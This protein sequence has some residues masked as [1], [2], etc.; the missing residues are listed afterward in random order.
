M[1]ARDGSCDGGLHATSVGKEP[2]RTEGVQLGLVVHVDHGQHNRQYLLDAVDAETGDHAGRDDSAHDPE[3]T[4]QGQAW[5]GGDLDDFD[6]L[7]AAFHQGLARGFDVECV[8][9]PFNTE[10]ELVAGNVLDGLAVKDG[11]A[12]EGQLV[13]D[14]Q[15]GQARRERCE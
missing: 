7:C 1:P 13:E 9:R 5:P 3:K 2:A 15:H 8:S 14:E 11:M 10:R 4:D 6:G 12:K